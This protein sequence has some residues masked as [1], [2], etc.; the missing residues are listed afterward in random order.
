MKRIAI[1]L[2]PLAFVSAAF[3]ADLPVVEDTDGN[4][5]WSIEELQVVWKDLTPET[6][7]AVDAN[8]DG[9][10]DATELQAAWDNAVIAAPA[11]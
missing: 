1:V 2:A 6:F 4:G 5:T 3:A 11:G 9:S 8:A 10:V 7:T